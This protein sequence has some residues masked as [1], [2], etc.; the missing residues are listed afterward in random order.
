VSEAKRASIL[1]AA[2]E[3]FL[4][5]G[6]SR[7][8]VAD[9]ARSADVS[10]ATLYKHFSSKEELFAAVAKEAATVVGDYT[11]MVPEGATPREL[12]VMF[13]RAYLTT[14]FDYHVNELMRIIIAEVPSHPKLVNEMVDLVIQRR[15]DAIQA[16]LDGL[17]AR[18]QLKPHNTAIGAKLCS[19]LIKEVFVWP[20]LF[21]PTYKLPDDSVVSAKI[22][23]AADLY[24][25]RFG[26]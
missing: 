24:L 10:T 14:Q 7:A 8:A 26:A 2:R 16:A 5:D 22:N 11:Q 17:V 1:K 23:A 25:A 20:A 4:K 9:I 21:D 15:Y 6:F 18:G 3:A 13:S 19:G 12:F